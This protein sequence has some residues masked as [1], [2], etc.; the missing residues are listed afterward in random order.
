MSCRKGPCSPGPAAPL[1]ISVLINFKL[2]MLWQIVTAFH[3][4]FESSNIWG[5]KY[6]DFCC[7]LN[8]CVAE[9]W[10]GLNWQCR[11][12]ILKE[13]KDPEHALRACWAA[14]P[15]LMTCNHSSAIMIFGSCFSVYCLVTI[16]FALQW[17]QRPTFDRKVFS[18]TK[19][20]LGFEIKL[21]NEL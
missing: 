18:F 17:T 10:M 2:K 4:Y 5:L 9:E 21:C 11:N 14:A 20:V 12:Y 7:V 19:A 3:I 16:Y 15:L 1:Y 6:S 13:F 8:I